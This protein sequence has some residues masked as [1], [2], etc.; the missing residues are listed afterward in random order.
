MRSEHRF[1]GRC[2]SRP[3]L[4]AR[5]VADNYYFFLYFFFLPFFSLVS[6]GFA[7]VSRRIHRRPLPLLAAAAARRRY[8][9]RS[10]PS[11]SGRF[12]SSSF[13]V[14]QSSSS[15]LLLIVRLPELLLVSRCDARSFCLMLSSISWHS[16]RHPYKL[17]YLHRNSRRNYASLSASAYLSRFSYSFFLLQ[18]IE[19]AGAFVRL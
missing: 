16:K 13:S 8:R 11:A 4:L 10:T 3:S 18:V 19:S 9:S 12:R 14:F 7:A 15:P 2:G 6:I 5:A 1:A 17:Q